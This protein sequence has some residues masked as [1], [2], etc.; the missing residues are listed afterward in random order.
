[1]V[2]SNIVEKPAMA[3]V[4][5]GASAGGVEALRTF[6][7]HEQGRSGAAFLVVM[8]LAAGRPTHLPQILGRHTRMT[9][10][11]AAP[12]MRL[13]PDAVYV[14][15]PGKLVAVEDGVLQVTDAN[16]TE[17]VPTIIDRTFN[18]LAESFGDCAIGMVLSG[19]GADGALGLKAIKERG[20]LTIAQGEDGSAPMFSGMPQSAVAAGVIDLQL[21]VE[22]IAQRLP[23][24]VAAVCGRQENAAPQEPEEN[25]KL[26]Q[27]ICA[28]LHAQV[29]HDF[30]GYKPSTFFRRAQRRMHVL[31]LP[32]LQAYVECLRKNPGE[33]ALLFRDL[34]ISVTSFFRDTEAFA[35]LQE[36]VIPELFK[37]KDPRE[38]VR[39]WVPGCATGEEAYSLGMLLLEH[40]DRLGGEAPSVRIFATDIDEHALGIARKGRYPSV[41]MDDVSPE[42]RKRFFIADRGQYTVHKRLRELCTFSPHNTLRD[43]PFSR[44]DLVSC[45]NLL[46]YLGPE[47][48]DRILPI[49]HYALR[50]GGFLFVGVAEG[51]TR[52]TNLFEPINRKHRIFQRLPSPPGNTPPLLLARGEAARGSHRFPPGMHGN[53]TNALRRQI[54]TRIL[55]A[56]APAYVLVSAQGEALFYSP[57][58]GNYLEFSPGAPS[59]QLLTN[60][61][62]ELR[63]GLRRALHEAVS[64][65]ARIVLPPVSLARE[66]GQ[67]RVQ[68]SVEPF[69]DGDTPLYLVLFEDH[70]PAPRPTE[71]A[72]PASVHT[73]EQLESE[74]LE[75]REQLQATYEE[76]E[77]AI[78]ELRVANE[79]LM[80]V[81]EELQSS[82]EELETSK[83]ELQS[84]NEELQTVNTEMTRHM[85]ALDQANADL[86]GLL[87]ST[88][89][90]TIFLDRR[91]AIRSYTRAA[92]EIFTLLPSDRG[93]LITDLAHQLEDFDLA[94]CLDRTLIKRKPVELAT[95]RRDG[96]RHYLTC[97]LPYSGHSEDTGG[98]VMTFVD[99]TA[100]AQADARHKLMI[101]ELNHRVRNMLAVVSAMASET[102][103]PL[104]GADT[105]D[106][107][108]DRLH[109][110]ARTYKLL[111]EANW[112]PMSFHELL[113]EE[114]SV[115]AG[116]A[117]F[118]M[119]GPEFD[120]Q[121]KEAL[122]L[123]MVVHELA[124]NAIKYGALSNDHGRVDIAWH[125]EEDNPGMIEM[126]W[127]ERDGPAVVPPSRKGF[128]TLLIDRQLAYEL[129]ARSRIDYASDGLAVTIRLPRMEVPA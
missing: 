100:L 64:A 71:V 108:L 88:G 11:Q 129:Q 30:H 32:S 1:V 76:F 69:D 50:P 107:F 15:P 38:E 121:P 114:L 124:I 81:N 98:I 79:E 96:R 67:R 101:G 28:I 5:I 85:E 68:I 117:R 57:R 27:E 13:A 21:S 2:A 90:A 106:I 60:A 42:R 35:T 48:Q 78:E 70:G 58:T 86:H 46:I 33:V 47:F 62:K 39:V 44:I 94:E 97:L 83:E 127:K 61:R 120:L 95:R 66:D 99:V 53:T 56:H 104:V 31:Q 18:S 82:N 16:P 80:S 89:I 24:I 92:T 8:H 14:V 26:R 43:P 77:T 55:Q 51:A 65:H 37:E 54:E 10:A 115:V 109:A 19:T 112:S 87:E 40:L 91:L 4:G 122:A 74:L 116:S 119:E 128:G 123:G 17:R 93:R 22:D 103:A 23:G 102:L 34:L 125:F 110:M 126:R 12:G 111:T 59:R 72:D 25:E 84:V 9:V 113:R 49:L 41:L 75:T 6:F 52:H 105:L 7:E 29:G 3:V 20:G 63:P 118:S 73:V 45:R 36:K